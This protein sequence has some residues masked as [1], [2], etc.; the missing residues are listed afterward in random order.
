MFRCTFSGHAEVYA[1]IGKALD[2]AIELCLKN[3]ED[4]VFYVGDRGEFDRMAASAVRAAKCRHKEK[5]IV[6]Y[7]VEP[8][9]STRINR[10]KDYL[11]ECYDSIIIPAELMGVHPKSAITK[12]N[13][14]MVDWCD[15]LIAYVYRD[16]GGAYQ[17]LQYA[18][19]EGKQIIN[20]AKENGGETSNYGDHAP[21]SA[22]LR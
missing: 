2:N 18:K 15:V 20:L 13:R 8:Y 22:A 6:L 7:L 12:R 3:A 11:T 16:F 1:D 14:L 17:T 4:V 10:D 5:N 9:M 19:R 21:D